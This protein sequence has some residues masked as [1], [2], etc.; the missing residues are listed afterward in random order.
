[1][2][3]AI[4][5]RVSTEDQAKHGYSLEGQVYAC[6]QKAQDLGATD[7]KVF[8]DEGS[9]STLARPGLTELRGLIRAKEFDSLIVYDPDRLHRKLVNQLVITEEIESKG[10]SLEFVNF[11]WKNTPEGRLFYQIRGAISEY[12]REKI[13]ERMAFG[14]LQKARQGKIPIGFDCLGYDYEKGTGNVSV[15]ETEAGTVRLIYDMFANGGKSINAIA[16]FLNENGIP[17]RRGRGIWH[18]QVVR[19]VLLRSEAYA[20]NWYY[21]ESKIPIDIPPIIDGRLSEAVSKRMKRARRLWAGKGHKKYL[22]SGIITCGD[23]GNTM[24]GIW[25]KNRAVHKRGY[26]CRKSYEGNKNAGCRPAKRLPANR[27]ETPVWDAVCN[28]LNN[29]MAVLK[30][31]D[32]ETTGREVSYQLDR[33][34][35]MLDQVQK[36]HLNIVDALASNLI[37]VDDNLYE[38][39]A[40]LKERQERLFSRKE[41]LENELHHLNN[42]ISPGELELNAEDI[43]KVMNNLNH[44]DRKA[45]L[46]LLVKQVV[47][48]GRGNDLDIAIYIL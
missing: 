10:V 32:Y 23:C 42:S 4:Y 28:S 20:G 44:V 8:K 15:N 41:R 26:T 36:G 3:F 16:G 38:R 37:S 11:E 46:R 19:Q 6:R 33:T 48:T 29:P 27:I 2:R 34:R 35:R 7:I 24:C 14:K 45:L 17:T 5:A 43:L 21:G 1:M 18:R 40:F 47:V 25:S 30:E 39:V 22:L 9:G 12:E 13:R 31:L